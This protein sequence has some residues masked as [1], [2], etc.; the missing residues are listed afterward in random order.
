MTKPS[1]ET[2]AT[3][4]PVHATEFV[5]PKPYLSSTTTGWDGLAAQAFNVPSAMESW[6]A[7]AT[8]DI[9]LLLLTRRVIRLEWRQAHGLWVGGIVHPG[10]L[11][12]NWGGPAREVRWWTLSAVPAQ[13]LLLH[14]SRELVEDVAQ[15]VASLDLA[16][17]ELVGHAGF[18]DPLL[19]QIALALW[20]ELEQPTPAG[21]SY[22]Q[23]A[24]QLLA[25]HLVRWY[26]SSRPSPGGD[27]PSSPPGLTDYQL[28]QVLEYIQTHLSEDLSLDTLAKQVGFSSYHFARLFRR[29][30]GTSVHQFVLCQ[31]LERAQQLLK[32]TVSPL[33]EVACACGFTHQSHFTLVFKQQFG[34]TPRYYRQ[35]R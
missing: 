3:S 9:S 4:M 33:A 15:E 10:E 5:A 24:A 6:L 25:H 16:G 34:Y 31:R 28:Q 27:A 22:A 32:E 35:E 13:T 7:S 30:A 8:P 1:A 14:L 18:R 29:A 23:A 21:K 2:H 19:T 26:T 12:L 20:R 17:L 11:I